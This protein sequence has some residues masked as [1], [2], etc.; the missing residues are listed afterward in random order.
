MQSILDTLFPKSLSEIPAGEPE[1]LQYWEAK[2]GKAAAEKWKELQQMQAD[3]R[4]CWQHIYE[5]GLI[6]HYFPSYLMR[7]RTI[8]ETLMQEFPEKKALSVLDLGAGVGKIAIGLSYHLFGSICTVESSLPAV[9]LQHEHSNAA[10]KILGPAPSATRILHGDYTK[11][12]VHAMLREHMPQGFDVI[13][14]SYPDDLDAVH[15]AACALARPETSLLTL[16]PMNVSYSLLDHEELLDYALDELMSSGVPYT[17][18]RLL[19]S[20]REL[21]VM[22]RAEF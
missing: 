16:F 4:E 11:P 13:M 17:A 5:S 7:E 18:G 14:S 1:I 9:S 2:V 8:L 21:M 6:N 19:R 22:A 3:S 15:Q 10:A 20:D 12:E